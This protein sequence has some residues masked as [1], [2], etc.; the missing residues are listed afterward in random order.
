[1]LQSLIPH[2]QRNPDAGYTATPPRQ[3]RPQTTV[4]RH[5]F[6]HISLISSID[7]TL[8][9]ARLYI[10]MA[11]RWIPWPGAPLPRDF[12]DIPS[13][14]LSTRKPSHHSSSHPKATRPFGMSLK[15]TSQMA[16]DST[17]DRK[18]SPSLAAASRT[19][20]IPAYHRATQ[21]TPLELSS[22]PYGS[23]PRPGRCAAPPI[24]RCN[25]S[26]D[27]WPPFVMRDKFAVPTPPSTPRI[28]RLPTPEFDGP[29]D[30]ALRFCCCCCCRDESLEA[31]QYREERR[32][33][34]TQR[35]DLSSSYNQC[36]L[37][38]GKPRPEMLDTA[39][40]SRH[41]MLMNNS[42]NCGR[43]HTT[44]VEKR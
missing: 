25:A 18:G 32:K 14:R 33:M 24:P 6:V 10:R 9:V 35:K 27:G 15:S 19:T 38:S 36:L 29:L 44:A 5:V 7:I 12:T 2:G 43:L 3:L 40:A 13:R 30:G 26:D 8:A 21:T 34:D 41:K 22:T 28:P 16:M 17:R 37:R 39:P 23:S 31:S 11:S 20:M 42:R 4:S 1:M